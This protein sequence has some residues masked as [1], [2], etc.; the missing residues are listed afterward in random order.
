[1]GIATCFAGNDTTP[2]LTL[3]ALGYRVIPHE[4]TMYFTTPGHSESSCWGNGTYFGM[5]AT[6]NVDCSTVTT[7]PQTQAS[8]IR[9][10]EVYNQLEGDGMIY[11]VHCTA[12]FVG[13]LVGTLFPSNC[14]TLVPGRTFQAERDRTTLWI[15]GHRGGNLGPEVH[16]KFQLLDI[17][18]KQVA[19]VQPTTTSVPS[20]PRVN[21][22]PVPS[23]P[24]TFPHG[25]MNF[26]MP[27]AGTLY[28]QAIT[29]KTGTSWKF[30][31]GTTEVNCKI[32]L[33]SLPDTTA[34]SGEVVL[35]KYAAGDVV[36]FCLW[37]EYDSRKEW[38]FSDLGNDPA[39]VV[40]FWDTG[41]TLHQGGKIITQSGPNTWILHL[42][43]AVSYLYDDSNDDIV[44]Q[45]SV[46]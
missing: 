21:S 5:T 19:S 20:A 18:P 22:T 31:I 2:T 17:S 12:H 16:I 11:T 3:T 28:V 27:I 42:D 10:A 30:G 33:S 34:P 44:L 1:V 36:R 35:G 9:S 26:N 8:T 41:N 13:S 46:R 4:H 43:N 6:A 39:S 15:T 32:A 25:D 38:A 23:T 37:S 7:P 45:L 40:A 24:T 14:S 29:A